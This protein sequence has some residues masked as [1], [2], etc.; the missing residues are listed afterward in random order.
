MLF[1]QLPS[2]RVIDRTKA[3][4]GLGA[5][6]LRAKPL[7]DT[8]V[9]KL[10]RVRTGQRLTLT[11][12]ARTLEDRKAT[13]SNIL[14]A[15]KIL[16]GGL[17][18]GS[19]LYPNY[20]GVRPEATIPSRRSWLPYVGIGA[21]IAIGGT[22]VA[23]KHKAASS[24][25]YLL[26]KFYDQ[27]GRYITSR[28]QHTSTKARG[29][30]KL[31]VRANIS[32][33]GFMKLVL[34]NATSAPVLFDDFKVSGLLD[35]VHTMVATIRPSDNNAM[36]VATEAKPIILL[37]DTG[38]DPAYNVTLGDVVVTGSTAPDTAHE[39]TNTMIILPLGASGGFN[40]DPNNVPT[41]T[42]RPPLDD[43]SKAINI[44]HLGAGT[45][46]RGTAQFTYLLRPNAFLQIAVSRDAN[47]CITGSVITLSTSGTL[48]AQF[49]LSPTVDTQTNGTSGSVSFSGLFTW[50]IGVGSAGYGW[51]ELA[52]YNVTFNSDGSINVQER[53]RSY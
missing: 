9:S 27:L 11:V 12:W 32:G 46:T 51:Q 37:D 1:P 34:G 5:V 21:G 36:V 44:G 40:G 22:D 38:D 15:P 30:Q 39:P 3:R 17:I 13:G 16:A 42:P 25:P 2:V 47:N 41:T 31:E 8:L 43:P 14:S 50:G 48:G 28:E 18:L 33:T 7:S 6:E 52:D 24:G 29:W 49:T 23:L 19:A 10:I 4:T 45:V 20:M 26:I 53:R 35:P